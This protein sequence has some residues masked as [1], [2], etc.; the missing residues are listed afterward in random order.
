MSNRK[1]RSFP[2][3]QQKLI[4]SGYN[5]TMKPPRPY[6][7]RRPPK[8]PETVAE[9]ADLIEQHALKTFNRADGQAVDWPLVA[10]SLFL[11]AYRCLDKS[12]DPARRE[13]ILRRLE[14]ATYDRIAGNKA[15]I[16]ASSHAA[17]SPAGPAPSY[18][19]NPVPSGPG[20]SF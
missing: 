17:P 7:A 18:G 15:D 10:E 9:G 2:K 13:S 20:S 1:A 4:C 19:P 6:T 11:I 5:T 16:P 8:R 14:I 12:A 3:L